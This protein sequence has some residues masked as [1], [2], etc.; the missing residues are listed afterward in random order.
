MVRPTGG[1]APPAGPRG[2]RD[3]RRTGSLGRLH[4]PRRMRALV[5]ALALLTASTVW[6]AAPALAQAQLTT[7]R[8]SPHA[9]VMQTVGLTDLAV[10]YHRPAVGGRRIW[11]DLVPYGEVWRAGANENT[12]F[13]TS[14]DVRVEGETLPAGSLV[15]GNSS[16][17][18]RGLTLHCKALL[19]WMHLAFR[20]W[21]LTFCQGLSPATSPASSPMSSPS[22]VRS[23]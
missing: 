1:G 15:F 13:E 21:A 10:D 20:R 8:V 5:F 14:T 16:V 11:G 7:P 18:H 4:L 17:T 12:V 6:S 2:V 23:S 22:A 19:M 3:P 9:R